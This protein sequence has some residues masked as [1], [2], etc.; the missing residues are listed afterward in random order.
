MK[1]VYLFQVNYS[2]VWQGRIQYWLPYSI[3]CLVAYAKTIPEINDNFHFDL[4]FKREDPL[5]VIESMDN[6]EIVG[7][8]N[9]MW[10]NNYQLKIAKLVK[11]KWPECI[12]LFGGPSTTDEH[13]A[14][15]NSIVEGEGEMTF[16][17][18]LLDHL[19]DKKIIPK[20]EQKRI[21][22]LSQLPSPYLSGVFDDI[23]EQNP[24]TE[25][26]ATFETNR[27]CPYQCTFCD[28]G[29][30]TSSKVKKFEMDR[31]YSE[32][33]WFVNHNIV[34]IFLADA[35]FGIFKKRD[36]DIVDYLRKSSEKPHSK[37]ETVSATF[38]KNQTDISIEI[39]ERLGPLTT[40]GITISRQSASDESLEAIKRT[41]ISREKV[42][43]I[44]SKAN[45]KRLPYY[46]ELIF[47]MPLETVSSWMSGL[48]DLMEDGNHLGLVIHQAVILPGAE[49]ADPEYIKKYG[50]D[51]VDFTGVVKP[52]FD[53]DY[54]D[55]DVDE[56]YKLIRSTNIM[57]FDESID[58]RLFTWMIWSFHYKLAYTQIISRYLRGRHNISYYD[59]YSEFFKWIKQNDYLKSFI[60]ELRYVYKYYFTEGKSPEASDRVE[61][62]NGQ[63]IFL[64]GN[65]YLESN[66]EDI[67]DL[68]V[69]FVKNQFGNKLPNSIINL[70]KNFK[71]KKNVNYPIDIMSDYNIIEQKKEKCV[72]TLLD[73]DNG[74]NYDGEVAI[75][76]TRKW[77]SL[78]VESLPEDNIQI[79]ELM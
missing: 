26:Q 34:F 50:L 48:T 2:I 66:E 29:S 60:D 43:D 4:R 54:S 5:K 20:Y 10:N 3:G 12:I 25:F 64:L 62:V 23:I 16:A 36:F 39:M 1:N 58:M 56:S 51:L 74:K 37:I 79:L 22:E 9:Y 17:Q 35:N 78:T 18:I 63:N 77:C 28:W 49:M 38:L 14:Y 11:E 57:T 41:N 19:H 6:P 40:Q 27:G 72:Y 45:D 75:F 68:I 15:G 31:I 67:E 71:L 52:A 7:F 69:E 73:S 32:I 53:C 61:M 21:T 46:L 55:P 65:T 44:I 13:L 30:L 33:D 8:S 47:P 42:S 59:F 24:T 76:L 70:Q